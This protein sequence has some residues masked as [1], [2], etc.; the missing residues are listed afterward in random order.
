M[1]TT[2]IRDTN[3]TQ[4]KF[5]MICGPVTVGVVAVALGF[6]FYSRVLEFV[7]LGGLAKRGKGKR[8]EREEEIYQTL[9]RRHTVEPKEVA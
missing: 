6:A 1:N 3:Y 5:W 2:D 8:M 7:G 9:R 4:A